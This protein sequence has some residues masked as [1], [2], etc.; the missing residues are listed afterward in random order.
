MNAISILTVLIAIFAVGCGQKVVEEN[1][2]VNRGGLRYEINSDDPF[3]GIV[4]EYWPNGQKEQEWEYRDGKLH[5][6][7]TNWYENGQKWS[8]TEFRDGKAHGQMIVWYK[9]GKKQREG[10]FRNG[11][12]ISGKCWDKNGNP[13]PCE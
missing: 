7:T 11:K 2:L 5:G 8:E 10:A 6:T 9:N 12:P 3:T 4:V 13:E 1:K